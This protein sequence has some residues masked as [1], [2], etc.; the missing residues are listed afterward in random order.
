MNFFK[1]AFDLICKSV[2]ISC[3]ICLYLNFFSFFSNLIV[4]HATGKTGILFICKILT[5]KKGLVL[6]MVSKGLKKKVQKRTVYFMLVLDTMISV[7]IHVLTSSQCLRPNLKNVS[8]I[9]DTAKTWLYSVFRAGAALN[10]N[11]FSEGVKI[12]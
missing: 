4:I 11:R 9:W 6:L 10:L 3:K 12:I 1:T 7:F 8:Q 5:C 2:L